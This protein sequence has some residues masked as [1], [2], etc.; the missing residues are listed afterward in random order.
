MSLDMKKRVAI[1]GLG[2]IGKQFFLACMEQG[3]DWEFFINHTGDLD[4]I[5]YTLKHDSVHPPPLEHISHDGKHLIFGKRKIKVF[6]ELDPEKLPWK[7]EGID[8]VVECTGHFTERQEVSKH[9]RAGAKKVLISAPAHGHDVT[10]VHGVNNKMLK[11]EHT[12]V[13][14]ASC[15]TNCV[16]LLVK[17]LHDSC[18]I[19]NAFFITTHAYTA[20]QK[21][22][23]GHDQKDLRRGRAAAVDIVPSTSGASQSV[24]EAIPEVKGRLEGYA[25]RVPVADGSIATLIASVE[26]KI[27]AEDVNKLFMHKAKQIMGILEYTEDPIVSADVIHNPHSCIF[28][29]TLTRVSGNLVSIAGWYDNEWGYSCRLVD[30]ARM[31]L[32]K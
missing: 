25:L 23:D 22:I 31:M 7:K 14:A 26:K 28:D 17:I 3:V 19:Q 32:A 1:N 20:T 11:Q 9:L 18:H 15:T 21:L 13:S 5:V 16:A 6:Y 24:I 10:V 12:L 2:R 4:F 30:V 8:L 27:S 29:A